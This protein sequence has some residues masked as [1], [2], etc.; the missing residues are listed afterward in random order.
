[1]SFR[2]V[3]VA[4]LFVA[5]LPGTASARSMADCEKIQ[6]GDAYNRC[7][8][9]F[10]PKRSAPR[11]SGQAYPYAASGGSRRA[12]RGKAARRSGGAYRG[13]HIQRLKGGRVRTIIGV[14]SRRR[15]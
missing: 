9:S 14:P 8:A 1:M 12:V 4:M 5:A 3:A 15:R 7:L 13:L 6:D 10:G 11:A 2:L